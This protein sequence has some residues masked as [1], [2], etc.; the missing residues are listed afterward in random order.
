M[1]LLCALFENGLVPWEVQ[2]RVQVSM[3]IPIQRERDGEEQFR[4]RLAAWSEDTSRTRTRTDKRQGCEA[5]TVQI[6]IKLYQKSKTK[7]VLNDIKYLWNL[8]SLDHRIC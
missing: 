5:A 1:Q 2:L 3:K 4:D 8:L 6:S 7:T